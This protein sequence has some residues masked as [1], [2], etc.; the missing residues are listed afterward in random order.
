MLLATI[1]A[2]SA[3]NLLP[4]AWLAV[5]RSHSDWIAIRDALACQDI[6]QRNSESSDGAVASV[7]AAATDE[8][9][10]ASH[11]SYDNRL[12]D[13]RAIFESAVMSLGQ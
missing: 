12:D 6:A 11:V 8:T 2:N 7:L 9:T 3:T 4:K 10:S 13:A 1:R 5:N